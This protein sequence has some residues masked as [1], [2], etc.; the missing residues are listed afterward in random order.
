[1][2][3]TGDLTRNESFQTYASAFPFTLVPIAELADAESVLNQEYLSGKREGAGFIGDDYNLYI[4]T[5][6]EPTDAWVLAGGDGTADIT[7]A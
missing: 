6:S 2:P 5:G 4:A 3:V 1:M 7:P